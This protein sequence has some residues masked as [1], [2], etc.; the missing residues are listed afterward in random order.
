MDSGSFLQ[1]VV[2]AIG[3]SGGGIWLCVTQAKAVPAGRG[4]VSAAL[5]QV[6]GRWPGI[7]KD[8]RQ[9]VE[10][11]VSVIGKSGRRVW[12]WTLAQ[13]PSRPGVATF[14]ALDQVFSR[15][16]GISKDLRQVVELVVSAVGISERGIWI[17]LWTFAQ[18]PSRSCVA[19]FPALDQA[20]NSWPLVWNHLHQVSELVVCPIGSFIA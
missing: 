4:N 8:L 11:V 9:V 12:L 7:S 17:W 15:W 1:L 18:K 19:T 6:F 2:S 10:L 5:D 3:T 14:A 20:F 13:K 16:P